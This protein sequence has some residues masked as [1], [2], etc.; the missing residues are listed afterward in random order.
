MSTEMRLPTRSQSTPLTRKDFV[1]NQEVRWCPGCGDYAILAQVQKVLPELGIPRENIVFISGIGCSSRFPYYMNTYGIHSIHGRAPTLAS[2]LAGANPELSIWVVTGDGDGLSIGGNHLL[3]ACRRN[4]NLNILL[5]NNR[6]Y[7][8]TKG[9]YSPTSRQG[10]RTKSSPMGSIEQPLNPL[11]VALGAE[12]TFVARTMDANVKHLGEVLH[13]AAIHQGTSF[14]EIYQNCVIFNPTEWQSLSDRSLRDENLLFLEHG[15]PLIFGKNR[16]KGIRLNGTTPEVVPLGNGI[17][18]EDLLVHDAQEESSTLAYM[19]SRLDYPVYPVPM[20]V[21]RQVERPTYTDGLMGQIADARAGRGAG[22]L[23]QLYRSA[24]LWEVTTPAEVRSQIGGKVPGG[25]NDE[26]MDTLGERLADPS[27]LQDQLDTEWIVELQPK[28]PITIIGQTSL[29]NAIHQM[30]SHNIGCL[31]VTDEQGRLTGIF[32]ERDVL[33]RVAGLVE[34]LA[35]TVVA[36]YMTPEPYALKS[37]TSIKHAL[38]LMSVHGFRH[39]PLVNDHYQPEGIISFRDV[40]HY[41]KVNFS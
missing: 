3:H 34:D 19:L 32:T 18:E 35:G 16:D 20:G 2:G 17:S 38:H 15:R 29:A 22:D 26:Y 31:L 6:I 39:V 37:N 12:A 1:S 36:D 8:L 30:N 13:A 24:D 11:A 27:P 9:Q 10:T 28:T 41:L 14:V 21:L 7:G 25:L 23:N 5:F 40:V 33:M 4:M